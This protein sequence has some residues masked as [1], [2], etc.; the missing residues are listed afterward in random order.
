VFQVRFVQ[1]P[2]NSDQTDA[3]PEKR[4]NESGGHGLRDCERRDWNQPPDKHQQN[5]EYFHVFSY[6]S[7]LTA[8]S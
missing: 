8:T 2:K 7:G 4:E 1:N 5:S 3:D 6:L